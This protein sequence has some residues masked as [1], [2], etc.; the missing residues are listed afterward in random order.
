MARNLNPVATAVAE[1]SQLGSI[2]GISSAASSF[3]RRNALDVAG[4]DRLPDAGRR[5]RRQRLGDSGKG[6]DLL[7]QFV[8][9]G[10]GVLLQPGQHLGNQTLVRIDGPEQRAGDLG[11]DAASEVQSTTLR[12]AAG[13]VEHRVQEGAGGDTS[14]AEQRAV[15]VPQHGRHRE[16]GAVG[17]G[18]SGHGCRPESAPLIPVHDILD[19]LPLRLGPPPAQRIAQWQQR[20]G[21]RVRRQPEQLADLAS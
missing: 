10:I 19:R 8:D 6:S 12:T 3:I 11:V 4:D 2:G 21:Q 18:W 20:H 15:D 13:D 1:P 14:R 16:S 7:A 9:P 17:H 5:E